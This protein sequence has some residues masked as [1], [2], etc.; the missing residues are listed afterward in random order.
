[1]NNKSVIEKL[2]DTVRRN[3]DK[4]KYE[5]ALAAIST[6]AEIMYMHNQVYTDEDLEKNLQIIARQIINTN[7]IQNLSKEIDSKKQILFYDG[8]GLDTRGLALIFVKALADLGYKVIYVTKEEAKGKQPRIHEVTRNKNIEWIYISMANGYLRWIKEL[9]QVFQISR[10]E[11]AF[12]YTIPND[13]AATVVFDSYKSKVVRFQIDL[14]DHAFWLG[15]YAFDYCIALRDLGAKIAYN[16]RKIPEKQ[17]VM[18]PYYATVNYDEPFAGFPFS[19]DG[20]RVV[21]SG[22]SLYKTLGDKE[23]KYYKIVEHI[24]QNHEDIIFMYAGSGDDSQLKILQQKYH[25][26]VYHIEE[27]KD[28]YQVLQHCVLYL[29]TYPMFGGLMMNYAATAGKIP[30]TLKH[31]HDADGLL[32]NQSNIKIE[33]EDIDTLLADVD[34]LLN[35]PEYLKERET[36]LQGSVITENKFKKELQMLIENQSTSFE[37][38]LDYV[39]TSEFRQ[40]FDKRFDLYKEVSNTLH[41]KN[42]RKLIKEFPIMYWVG[43]YKCIKENLK[44]K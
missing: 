37:Y 44:K 26:R 30:I 29:N 32:F 22:G 31:N 28:L 8:F 7:K 9:N 33:Y 39:D 1:M 14:T 16:Y 24:L 2:K 40:E 21:F 6:C 11:V 34:L 12:F 25:G 13:V 17:I 15:K 23:N 5:E 42:N 35:D 27:R 18:L 38:D 20:K 19:T 3:V 4:G 36:L 43:K 10:P 41:R